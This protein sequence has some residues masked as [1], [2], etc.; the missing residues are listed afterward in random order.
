MPRI[1]TALFF[2]LFT[3]LS[4]ALSTLGAQVAPCPC[5]QPPGSPAQVVACP[6]IGATC[7][8]MFGTGE[9]GTWVRYEILPPGGEPGVLLL[10]LPTAAPTLIDPRIAVCN[11]LKS[12]PFLYLGELCLV[13]PTT[14]KDF[15]VFIPFETSL[16]GVDIVTQHFYRRA[17][18]PPGVPP[19]MSSLVLEFTITDRT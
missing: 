4:S 16:I 19:F 8:R 15:Y 13:A 11:D 9:I 6:C 5:P 14:E 7:V 1:R 2:V 18:D 17:G 12:N 10:G 3:G